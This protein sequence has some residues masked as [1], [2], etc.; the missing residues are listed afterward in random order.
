MLMVQCTWKPRYTGW[1]RSYFAEFVRWS[2]HLF[3]NAFVNSAMVGFDACLVKGCCNEGLAETNF[4]LK[5]HGISFSMIDS[6]L[7]YPNPSLHRLLPF[8]RKLACWSF[9]LTMAWHWAGDR[10]LPESLSHNNF[11]QNSRCNC[12]QTTIDD[13]SVLLLVFAFKYQWLHRPLVDSTFSCMRVMTQTR[14]LQ[15]SCQVIH[16]LHRSSFV[17]WL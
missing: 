17:W 12:S 13:C 5:S 16:F 6:Q 3:T 15:L 8:E 11:I 9:I 2:T 7:S 1:G 4:K 10:P 14:Q